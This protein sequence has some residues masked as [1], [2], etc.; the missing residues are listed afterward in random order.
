MTCTYLKRCTVTFWKSQ[1]AVPSG[2]GC[3]TELLKAGWRRAQ[4]CHSR[5]QFQS[6]H[7]APQSR[8]LFSG[9]DPAGWWR[10]TGCDT[11]VWCQTAVHGIVANTGKEEGRQWLTAV[12]WGGIGPPLATHCVLLAR[13]FLKSAGIYIYIFKRTAML[14]VLVILVHSHHSKCMKCAC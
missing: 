2:G 7:I 8:R 3:S 6:S 11:Q 1:V 13:L 4:W 10:H 14:V 9:C 12:A 5:A